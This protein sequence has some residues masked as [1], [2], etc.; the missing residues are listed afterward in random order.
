MSGRRAAREAALGGQTPRASFSETVVSSGTGTVTLGPM[1]SIAF[2]NDNPWAFEVWFYTDA[3]LDSMNLISR[4][5]EFVLQTQGDA[6]FVQITGMG[7]GL[8]TDSILEPQTWHLVSVSSDGMTITI[9][10]DGDRVSFQ[11]PAGSGPSPTGN[12]MTIGGGFYGQ[13]DSVRC[14]S[15]SV[16]PGQ[17]YEYQF[18]DYAGGTTGLEAQIDF[19]QSPPVDS[20]GNNTPITVSADGVELQTFTPAVGFLEEGFCI[21]YDDGSINPGG[22]SSD[23][24][25]MSWVAPSY[26]SGTQVVFSNGSFG[27]AGMSLAVNTN[28]NVVFQVGN[29]TP[30]VSN[31]QL[32]ESSWANIAAT[33]SSSSGAAALFVNGNTDNIATLTFSTSL[34]TGA[35]LIGAAATTGGTPSYNFYGFVQ[36]V[37]LWSTVLT[38]TS[39]QTYMTTPPLTDATCIADYDFSVSEPMNNVTANQ[40]GLAGGA[41]LLTQNASPLEFGLDDIARH[42]TKRTVR[43]GREGG[44]A[45][46]HV[47]AA[48]FSAERRA[49]MLAEFRL[50]MTEK[51]HIP[52]ERQDFYATR[53][54]ENLTRA[55]NDLAAGTYRRTHYYTTE[56]RPD[57]TG[58]MTLHTPGG[59][60]VIY[61]GALDPCTTWVLGFIWDILMVVASVLGFAAKNT[62]AGAA[63]VGY[64]T[65]KINPILTS[66]KN[67]FSGVGPSGPTVTMIW[68]LIKV[69]WEADLLSPL[70]S[71]VW[72]ALSQSISW[73]TITRIVAK[74]ALWFSPWGPAEVALFL[75]E[76]AYDLV[77]LVDDWNDQPSNCWSSSTVAT[78]AA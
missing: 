16:P 37:D 35:P 41:E 23:F 76:L 72:E 75:A 64:L 34:A 31:A 71:F 62:Q 14:W 29:A 70:L 43:Q 68:N 13:I 67:C 3:L 49:E 51:L 15:T 30:L 40:I 27:G 22:S 52:A 56:R 26:L 4:S 9:Y 66:L 47:T 73:W 48:D 17:V 7:G 20:S 28:G 18:V 46:R 25:I 50:F 12:P 57:G 1:S 19:T 65:A 5:G 36:S 77:G 6:L 8:T 39:V 60:Y 53:M 69:L 45:P 74:I 32:S 38:Q 63:F 61:D 21:P 54:E 2:N 55:A 24:S 59:S 11:T 58:M 10:V 44:F 33:W 42:A 78:Q